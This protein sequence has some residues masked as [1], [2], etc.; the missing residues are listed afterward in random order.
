MN[1]RGCLLAVREISAAKRF[2]EEVLH[3]KVL[4]DLGEH[5]S[6][7]GFSLQQGYAALIGREEGIKEPSHSFQ[8]YFE[9]EDLEQ[10]YAEMKALPGLEWV[11]EI[12]EYPWGQRDFRLYD[13]DGHVVEVAENM[14]AVIRRFCGQGMPE[15]EVAGRTM[16]PLEEVKRIM[17]EKNR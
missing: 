2:Y 9:V 7:G 5:V 17:A 13:P 15:E 12:R 3:Q 14:E 11:H 1:Y 10:A 16:Y 8:V 4:M 6:F